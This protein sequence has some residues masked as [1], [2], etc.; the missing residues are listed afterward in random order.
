V[1]DGKEEK[2]QGFDTI[3][4]AMGVKSYNPLEKEI[5]DKVAE[6][7]VVGD[8]AKPGKPSTPLRRPPALLKAL[9]VSYARGGL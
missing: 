5:K 4:L 9:N 7:F 2:L 8:A 1:K 3:I 6:V